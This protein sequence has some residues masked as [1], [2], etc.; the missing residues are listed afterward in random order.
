MKTEHNWLDEVKWIARQAGAA[1][2]IFRLLPCTAILACLLLQAGGL[3]SEL[4]EDRS[5]DFLGD[6]AEEMKKEIDADNSMDEVNVTGAWSID[7][8]GEPREKMKLYL[9]QNGSLISGQGAIMEGEK[10]RTATA[11]GLISGSEMNLTVRTEAVGDTYH[12]N[13]SLS[14]LAGGHY[15]VHQ[16][17]GS[18]R[19]GRFTFAVSTNIFRTD[20]PEDEWQL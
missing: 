10:S 18:S 3:P 11:R 9:V 16:A 20:A 14:S 6:F 13:L 2:M 4:I 1:N 15:L 5:L 7:L 12:L 19:S 8:L 17:D